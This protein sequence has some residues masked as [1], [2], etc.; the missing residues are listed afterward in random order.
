MQNSNLI[1][2]SNSFARFL[3][4]Y[5]T[6]TFDAAQGATYLR[7]FYRKLQ[8]LENELG[9]AC[10]IARA[11][12]RRAKNRSDK[13]LIEKTGKAAASAAVD[14]KEFRTLKSNVVL[15]GKLVVIT[16][17]VLAAKPQPVPATKSK[18]A[19]KAA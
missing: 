10:T 4:A 18:K 9:H 11:E 14:F 3:N 16:A 6:N 1:A 2:I 8:A 13:A 15:M 17:H 19:S 12:E 5:S 7:I